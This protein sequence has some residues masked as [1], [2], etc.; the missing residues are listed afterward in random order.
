MLAAVLHRLGE[1]LS[2][3]ERPLPQPGS[4]QVRV[5]VEACGVCHTDLHAIRG[6]WHAKPRLPCTPG[7]EICG[8][9]DAIGPDVAASRLGERVGVFWLNRTCGQCEWCGVGWETLCPN[10]I[11]TGFGVP[12]GF[13]EALVVDADFAIPIPQ[14]LIPLEAAPILCAGVSSYKG[15]RETEAKPGD[16]IAIVGVGGVGHLAIQYA[17]ALGLRP[18]AIDVSDDALALAK[19]LGV[20]RTLNAR[21]DAVARTLRKD[22]GGVPAVLMT[23]SSAEAIRLGCELLRRRGTMAIVGIPP[24]DFQV[25]TFDIVVKR[26]TIRGSIGGTRQDVRDALDLAALH[27]IRAKVETQPLVAVNDAF[28]RMEAGSVAGRIVLRPNASAPA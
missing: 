9:V 26:F 12:G 17:R 8:I 20:E 23:A 10:Q 18:L 21:T 11:N 1:P 14:T 28:A 13:A 22:L 2:I 25:P 19:S 4:G 24:G 6:D 27:G 16:W 3:E 7:H 15:I 5:R